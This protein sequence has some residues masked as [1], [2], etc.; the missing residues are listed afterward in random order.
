[1]KHLIAEIEGFFNLL[2]AHILTLFPDESGLK[3]QLT[4]II[5][6]ISAAPNPSIIKYRMLVF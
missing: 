5:H 2:Y 3:E 6:T 1:M 4:P